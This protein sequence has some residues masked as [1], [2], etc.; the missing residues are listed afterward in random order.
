MGKK[1]KDQW[2]IADFFS[3]PEVRKARIEKRG[4]TQGKR[5]E[6][7]GE[8]K[9]ERIEM[10]GAVRHDRIAAGTDIGGLLK[11]K[12][13]TGLPNESTTVVQAPSSGGGNTGLYIAGAVG[14]LAVA[15]AAVAMSSGNKG[16]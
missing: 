4:K 14:L 15:G 8:T 9:R 3:N 12:N 11:G 16:S 6:E 2:N 13:A 7:R 10:K 5:I 1:S